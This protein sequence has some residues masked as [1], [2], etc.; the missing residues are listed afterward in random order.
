M[1]G[2]PIRLTIDLL[3]DPDYNDI[4]IANDCLEEI[5][6]YV[7]KEFRRRVKILDLT[8]DYQSIQ[9]DYSPDDF[10]IEGSTKAIKCN[11]SDSEN[12]R[13]EKFST[14]MRSPRSKHK[15]RIKGQIDEY[16]G[17]FNATISRIA[18]YDDADYWWARVNGGGL[19]E[20]IKDGKVRKTFE[21]KEFNED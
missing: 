20:F 16:A 11:R 17:L 5:S 12:Q 7:Q 4:D 15:Y 19:I 10:E 6:K 8:Y 3:I 14:D 21:F 13:L 1:Q 18:P 9:D 2:S